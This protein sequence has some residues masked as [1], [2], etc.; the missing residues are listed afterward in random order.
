MH[1]AKSAPSAS[2]KRR[3]VAAMMTAAAAAAAAAAMA[4]AV[5][6]AAAGDQTLCSMLE[7]IDSTLERIEASVVTAGAGDAATG[8]QQARGL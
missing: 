8:Q 4:G 6:A 3:A 7:K 2:L 5:D 1:M